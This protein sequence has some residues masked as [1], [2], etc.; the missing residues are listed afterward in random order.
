MEI[1]RDL[2]D[3]GRRTITIDNLNGI[4]NYSPDLRQQ[5]IKI[6]IIHAVDDKIFPMEKVIENS[7]RKMV[8]DFYS[9]KGTH[10]QIGLYR[11]KY[12]ELVN[13]ALD[14][15]EALSKQ[16]NFSKKSEKH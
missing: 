8:D 9:I 14:D 6:A 10:S 5:G 3:H 12:M 16:K 15:L 11:Q 1:L 4:K 2:F 7:S 13:N